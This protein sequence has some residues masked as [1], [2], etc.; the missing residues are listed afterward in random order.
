MVPDLNTRQ[1]PRLCATELKNLQQQFV[2]LYLARSLATCSLG[3]VTN[4]AE[5]VPDVQD[6]D[7]MENAL[8]PAVLSSGS[9]K[10]LSNTVLQYHGDG[11]KCVSHSTP[12]WGYSSVRSLR[13]LSVSMALLRSAI[14]RNRRWTLTTKTVLKSPL[15]DPSMLKSPKRIACV[16]DMHSQLVRIMSSEIN[17]V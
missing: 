12:V 13:D 14:K 4:A 15:C 11:Q 16:Q 2:Y 5:C 17:R 3:Q 7:A 6:S 8:K 9:I 10:T 1:P